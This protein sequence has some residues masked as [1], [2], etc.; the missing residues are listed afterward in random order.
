M[1]SM[2]DDLARGRTAPPAAPQPAAAP[3]AGPT[4]TQSTSWRQ[5]VGEGLGRARQWASEK[6]P[7]PA[8][9]S[10]TPA[11][12]SALHG[13]ERQAAQTW[14]KTARAAG[15]P[16]QHVGRPSMKDVARATPGAVR[17]A[18]SALGGGAAQTAAKA[19]EALAPVAR[20]A[21][22]LARVAGPA[23]T[24]ATLAQGVYGSATQSDAERD[25][26]YDKY[27]GVEPDDGNVVR[28]LKEAGANA[29]DLTRR[30]V[31]AAGG[32]SLDE[33]QK[34]LTG[35]TTFRTGVGMNSAAGAGRG[36]VN[37]ERVQP[38]GAP[39]AD[40]TAETFDRLGMTRGDG[41][42][43]GRGAVGGRSFA[44]ASLDQPQQAAE[45]EAPSLQQAQGRSP[46]DIMRG[47]QAF[48]DQRNADDEKRFADMAKLNI[49]ESGGFG[50]LDKR[51]NDIRNLDMAM[52]ATKPLGVSGKAWNARA[53]GLAAAREAYSTGK[54]TGTVTQLAGEEQSTLR[55]G[56]DRVL[57][58]QRMDAETRRRG[59]DLDYG[60]TTRGQDLTYDAAMTG[61]NADVTREKIKAAADMTETQRKSASDARD[62][63]VK[64]YEGLQKDI[65]RSALVIDPET[66]KPDALRVARMQRYVNAN[67]NSFSD[68]GKPI[69]MND[70]R[71]RDTKKYQELLVSTEGQFALDE[72]VNSYAGGWFSNKSDW[73]GAQPVGIEDAQGLKDWGDGAL[74]FDAATGRFKPGDRSKMVVFR[75]GDGKTTKVP[76]GVIMDSEHGP[77]M[78][79]YLKRWAKQNKQPVLNY[80]AS[81]S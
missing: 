14:N 45:P 72:L 37:P 36:V 8:A 6:L 52:R 19:A 48:Y 78:Q 12:P 40:K 13:A 18:A 80:S 20:A 34:N 17:S 81:G 79:T 38:E 42:G 71:S 41:A 60:A 67:A 64:G 53:Q 56:Q 25:A 51:T 57:E 35:Y 43:A 22:P 16:T 23:A 24:A 2:A 46:M 9:P 28:S 73:E 10:A 66:G 32:M 47:E 54:D 59:Q 68:G 15:L 75:T 62:A 5:R 50:L 26:M 33:A 69:D 63:Q 77:Q 7:G 49:G 11:K 65:E 61:H 3:A 1:N 4:A 55:R 70:L 58:G 76:V 21:A 39:E 29:G 30:T 74:I 44:E 27:A 31:A